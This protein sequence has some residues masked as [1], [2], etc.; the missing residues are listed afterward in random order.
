MLGIKDYLVIKRLQQ[1]ETKL[2]HRITGFPQFL[3]AH[4]YKVDKLLILLLLLPKQRRRPGDVSTLYYV[5]IV[6]QA[7]RELCDTE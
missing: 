1:E 6:A 4:W 5:T 7:L 2:L 3:Q